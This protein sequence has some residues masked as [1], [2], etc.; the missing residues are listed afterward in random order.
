MIDYTS[1][2]GE[3]VRFNDGPILEKLE[4]VELLAGTDVVAYCNAINEALMEYRKQVNIHR[5]KRVMLE[6]EQGVVRPDPQDPNY[7]KELAATEEV[8]TAILQ[9]KGKTSTEIDEQRKKREEKMKRQAETEK[10]LLERGYV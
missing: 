1:A 3:P 5:F 4:Q 10:L 6:K 7:Q 2:I 8:I 9:A